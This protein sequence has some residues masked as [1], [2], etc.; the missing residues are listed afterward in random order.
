MEDLFCQ[1]AEESESGADDWELFVEAEE[2]VDEVHV[3]SLSLGADDGGDW[4]EVWEGFRDEWEGAEEPDGVSDDH[5]DPFLGWGLQGACTG[6][7]WGVWRLA[8][9]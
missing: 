8:V 5:C 9:M 6:N 1:S 7:F 3:C 4:G 2:G